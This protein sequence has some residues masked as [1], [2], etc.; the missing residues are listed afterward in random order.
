MQTWICSTNT[1]FVPGIR[2]GP[3]PRG[4]SL[5]SSPALI[6]QPCAAAGFAFRVKTLMDFCSDK[7]NRS[8]FCCSCHCPCARL[9]VHRVAMPVWKVKT[10]PWGVVQRCS[11]SVWSPEEVY[12]G[13]GKEPRALQR[14]LR[15]GKRSRRV[16]PGGR[17][18]TCSPWPTVQ[19]WESNLGSF[20]GLVSS[21][22]TREGLAQWWLRFLPAL[23][24]GHATSSPAEKQRCWD[25]QMVNSMSGIFQGSLRLSS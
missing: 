13:W 14:G 2:S 7:I 22:V 24:Y 11:V 10:V 23:M 17:P 18:A 1:S 12:R 4:A 20:A 21:P 9:N 3:H 19:P 16:R 15:G 25:K 6:Y 8:V 5:S